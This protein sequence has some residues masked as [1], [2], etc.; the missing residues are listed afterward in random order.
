MSVIAERAR[1][2]ASEREANKTVRRTRGGDQAERGA[3]VG[4]SGAGKDAA[5]REGGEQ[6]SSPYARG[7]Q[8]DL[9]WPRPC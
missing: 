1:M 8:G 2:P 4:H 7:D 9:G 5:V 6:D 3:R